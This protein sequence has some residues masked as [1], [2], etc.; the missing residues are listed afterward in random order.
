MTMLVL[1]QGCRPHH[2][3]SVSPFE[4]IL[5]FVHGR[6]PLADGGSLVGRAPPFLTG[7]THNLLV[8]P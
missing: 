3:D 2:P 7:Q 6:D 5:A 1:G 4:H 8:L